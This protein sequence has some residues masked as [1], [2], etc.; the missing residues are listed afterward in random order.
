MWVPAYFKIIEENKYRGLTSVMV[1]IDTCLERNEYGSLEEERW[2]QIIFCTGS[3]Q[4]FWLEGINFFHI[5]KLFV[6]GENM[7][8]F[9]DFKFIYQ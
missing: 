2:K 7:R 4:C 8:T 6:V 9:S 1:S 3:S 5:T